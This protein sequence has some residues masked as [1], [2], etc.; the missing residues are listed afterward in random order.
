MFIYSWDL[1]NKYTKDKPLAYHPDE[2]WTLKPRLVPVSWECS[3]KE[4]QQLPEYSYFLSS[5]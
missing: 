5:W 1:L 4:F 2:R 3:I